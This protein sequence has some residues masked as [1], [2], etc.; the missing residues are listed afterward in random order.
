MK[1]STFWKRNGTPHFKKTRINITIMMHHTK[2]LTH[3]RAGL[4][5]SP[6]GCKLLASVV[7]GSSDITSLTYSLSSVTWCTL[8]I[9]FPNSSGEL[10]IF[11]KMPEG[12]EVKRKYVKLISKGA[13]NKERTEVDFSKAWA[14]KCWENNYTYVQIIHCYY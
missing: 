8:L 4:P 10:G 2:A 1:I 13:N 5:L 9:C 6:W 7:L 3:Q 11:V 14:K 12:C